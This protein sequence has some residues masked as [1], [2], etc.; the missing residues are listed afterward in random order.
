MNYL[1]ERF[2]MSVISTMKSFVQ[3]KRTQ[4]YYDSI[5]RQLKDGMLSYNPRTG[6]TTYST[7]SGTTVLK[8]YWDDVRL[9]FA[10]INARHSKYNPDPGVLESVGKN[11]I[12]THV[13]TRDTG[14]PTKFVN[15]AGNRPFDF[16]I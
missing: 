8:G 7:T 14:I 16:N 12:I 13:D 15:R 11:N 5:A 4:A 3:P 10:K 6:N 1:K 2:N 9:W